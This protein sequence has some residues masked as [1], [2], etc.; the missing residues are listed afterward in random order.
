MT[1]LGW[2]G[3]SSFVHSKKKGL[4]G[5][6]VLCGPSEEGHL[7]P[8]IGELSRGWFSLLFIQDE[9]ARPQC[10]LFEQS[11]KMLQNGPVR[12]NCV[13]SFLSFVLR[14]VFKRGFKVR[15]KVS[16]C[17]EYASSTSW[18]VVGL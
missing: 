3:R 9:E 7:S 11:R 4:C 13:N 18:Y 15:T 2:S 10:S 16:L 5:P 6:S 17:Y 8:N 14:V 12:S 1:Q